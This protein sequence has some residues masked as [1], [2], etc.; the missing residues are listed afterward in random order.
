[1][2]QECSVFNVAG[3]FFN[4]PTKEH[5]LLEI[6]HKTDLAHTSVKNYLSELVKLGILIETLD[7]KGKR[8]F[9]TYKANLESKEYKIYK[10]IHNFYKLEESGLIDYLNDKIMPKCIV[11]FGSYARAE[12]TEDSD[13]DLFVEGKEQKID[14][15]KYETLLK[16]KIQLH[17]KDF[18]KFNTE[19]KNN[20]ING[21]VLRGYLEACK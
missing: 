16:R 11:L 7:K 8:V 14:L 4:E 9:P 6:S 2:L 15:T 17:F 5:Y 18:Q 3:V 1:M 10:K 19:L 12:D 21:I 13:I 20:I